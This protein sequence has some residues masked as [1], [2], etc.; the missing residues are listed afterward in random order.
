MIKLHELKTTYE[1]VVKDDESGEITGYHQNR[2]LIIKKT[3]KQMQQME[4][5]KNWVAFGNG[6]KNNAAGITEISREEVKVCFF[7]CFY[8]HNVFSF[9]TCCTF[10]FFK[11]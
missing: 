8:T 2:T 4:M 9:L 1:P 10:V 3:K 7:F 6:N 11:K 5:R